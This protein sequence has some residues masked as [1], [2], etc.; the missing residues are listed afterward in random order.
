[1]FHRSCRCRAGERCVLCSS[2]SWQRRSRARGTRVSWQPQDVDVSNR[3]T[4]GHRGCLGVGRL[5]VRRP[6]S[7]CVRS[8]LLLPLRRTRE[9]RGRR[10][11]TRTTYVRPHHVSTAAPASPPCMWLPLPTRSGQSA[12]EPSGAVSLVAVAPRGGELDARRRATG[13]VRAPS[14][15]P[16]PARGRTP[17]TSLTHGSC[18]LCATSPCGS[19]AFNALPAASM[20]NAFSNLAS[21]YQ[22]AGT[23][24]RL[25]Y[26]VAAATQGDGDSDM[27]SG[28]AQASQPDDAFVV[29]RKCFCE[30]PEAV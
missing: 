14:A 26:D 27:H 28:G 30:S 13:C 11:S 15:P 1:M 3:C 9:A 22:L 10:F 17:R 23:F 24:S 5:S 7:R 25:E 19:Y 16:L 20:G 6:R 21:S 4:F 2:A 12:G 29:E 18:W 8:R